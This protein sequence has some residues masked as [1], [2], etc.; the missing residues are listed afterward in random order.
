MLLWTL[1]CTYLFK[2]F[3][4]DICPGIGLQGFCGSSTSRFSRF[5][6]LARNA[7]GNFFL[8]EA[9]DVYQASISRSSETSSHQHLKVNMPEPKFVTCRSSTTFS[10]QW[11]LPSPSPNTRPGSGQL[12]TVLFRRMNEQ[13][14]YALDKQGLIKESPHWRSKHLECKDSILVLVLAD[15]GP[16]L[17]IYVR[18]SNLEG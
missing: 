13:L 8:K 17:R 4:L 7:G 2:L 11:F 10:T 12:L 18:V 3:P 9:V 15:A 16:G 6:S 14:L 5:E 1:E